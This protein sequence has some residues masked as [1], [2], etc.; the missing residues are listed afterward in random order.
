MVRCLILFCLNNSD[1]NIISRR[2][3]MRHDT[4]HVVTIRAV[5]P[6]VLHYQY[7]LIGRPLVY[8]IYIFNQPKGVIL[9]FRNAA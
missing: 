4:N 1:I 7:V 9:L 5:I 3:L 8:R 6:I 2:F